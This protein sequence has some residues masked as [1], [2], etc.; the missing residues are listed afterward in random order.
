MRIG[1]WTPSCHGV[2]V[3]VETSK[4]D[5]LCCFNDTLKRNMEET[6]RTRLERAHL[7]YESLLS[8]SNHA[9][10]VRTSASADT[11]YLGRDV[12]T[13]CSDVLQQ[14]HLDIRSSNA[15]HNENSVN[16]RSLIPNHR[17]MKDDSKVLTPP[18]LFPNQRINK[19]KG[20][21]REVAEVKNS[22]TFDETLLGCIR[23]SG[24]KQPTIGAS[25]GR[26]ELIIDDEGYIVSKVCECQQTRKGY[27]R[28]SVMDECRGADCVEC[29]YNQSTTPTD[30][31]W[32]EKS[33]SI[34]TLQVIC[35]PINAI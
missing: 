31:I 2:H 24:Q 25:I 11:H 34:I 12:E 10:R 33:S 4:P 28:H 18:M 22:L 23:S 1:P 9:A 35:S 20:S 14:P 19:V 21:R 5:I 13:K 15:W 17:A 32:D 29:R 27:L 16:G 26:T 3:V 6:R 8:S 7:H 30:T